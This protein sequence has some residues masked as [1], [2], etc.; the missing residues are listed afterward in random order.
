M[1]V[2]AH[3]L[4]YFI[5]GRMIMADT[6]S[7]DSLLDTTAG[8]TAIVNNKKH[9][10]DVVSVTG[11]DW[12]TYAGKTASTIYVSGNNFIGF[13]Q[14]AEQLKIWRRDGAVYYIYRQEG[15]LTSGKRF[16]KIRVEGYVYYSITSSS[17]ALKYEV[18]L[19][20]GQTL[21]INV[22]QIPTSSSYTG[23]SSIT[24]GKT[25]TSLNIS[26][27][28]TVPISILVKNAGVSQEITYEKY[29]DLVIASITV[30]K[31]P[32]KTTYYQ[33]EL[34]DKTGLAI[35][36]TTSTGETVSVTDYE[37][38]GFDSSS[39][40]TKTITVTASGKT[41]TFEISVSEAS[42]TAIS[43]TTMP[44]KTNYHIG[45][46]FDSTGIVVTATASDGNTIDVTKDCTYSGFGSSSPKTNTITVTYG[47]L[48]TTFDVTIMQPLSI[49]GGNYSSDTYFVGETTDISVYS[50]T[51]SYSDGFEYVTSGYT[52]NNVVVTEPGSLLITVEY[53]GVSTTVS[54][55]VLDSFSVKI[56]TPTKDDV[57]AIFDLET[58]I[59]SIL[60]T[61]EFNNN[62]SDN[63][64]GIACPNSLYTRCKQIVFSDGITKIPSNFGSRFS[65][66]ENL[67]TLDSLL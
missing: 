26:I 63:A 51:V 54:T 1:G 41:T 36:G 29:S 38:S 8:M 39:A 11:V 30:S 52:V 33:K 9:D 13:G 25:T 5:D 7:F 2:T 34:L 35:S 12:F 24:D 59:L 10:N 18:F 32:D 45:K 64:E 4:F 42:I 6:V 65:S 40:G 27:S 20:E 23:T 43:V 31:M 16:L 47:I 50:I 57:T 21:F 61:G 44:T 37:L 15:T 56:G 66:L 19:I 46:E 62:L 22:V 49:T 28:S 48:T 53:F 3:A 60:G 17:Y 58:N 55:K 14:N 67:V